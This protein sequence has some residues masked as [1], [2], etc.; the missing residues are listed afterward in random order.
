MVK[1]QPEEPQALLNMIRQFNTACNWLSGIAFNEKLFH[2]HSLQKRTYSEVRTRFGLSSHQTTAAIRKV[3]SAYKI[4]TR[5]NNLVLFKPLGA[6]PI[7]RHCYKRNGTIRFY[8]LRIPLIIRDGMPLSNKH[9]AMLVYQDN[10]FLIHQIIEAPSPLGYQPTDFLGCDLGI[11]NILADSDGVIYSGAVLNGLRK[12]HRKLRA[13]L[14]SK[15]T[16][17]A[18][19]LLKKRRLKEKRFATWVNHNISKKVVTKAYD[20]KLGIAL[21]DLKGIRERIT[22]RKAQRNSHYSWSF[23]QLRQFIDYK[24]RLWGIPLIYVDPKN[25]SRTCPKCGLID[26][27]N[28][29]SQSVFRCQACDYSGHA[30]IIAAENIRRAASNQPNRTLKQ[31]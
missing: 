7:S 3:A 13:K 27:R 11:T 30:D 4:K 12:R 16:K 29:P 18:K 24:T 28:R 1:A 14:Q 23:N 6:I 19:R 2:W 15:G 21:E 5:R 25:T 9:Q 22:V 26:K 17:S 20:S 8:G 10:K 31:F